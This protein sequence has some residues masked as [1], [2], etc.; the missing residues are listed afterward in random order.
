MSWFK[1]VLYAL[2]IAGA[3][4]GYLKDKQLLQAGEDATLGRAAVEVLKV[5][6]YGRKLMAKVDAMNDEELSDLEKRLED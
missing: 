2:K 1:I 6:E 4:A 5:T 3:I